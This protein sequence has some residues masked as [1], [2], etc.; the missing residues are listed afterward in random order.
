MPPDALLAA[1]LDVFRERGYTE[2]TLDLVA[3]RAQV[4]PDRV[5]ARFA[6][7]DQLLAALLKAYSPL[8]D[9]EVALDSVA[10]ESAEE[11]LRDALHRLVKVAQQHTAFF[12]LALMDAQVNKGAFLGNLNAQIF[13]KAMVLLEKIKATGQL[14]PASD[15]IL[16]RTLVSLLLGFVLSERA[17]PQIARVAMRLVPQHAWLDG[18]ID[19]LLYGVLEDEAR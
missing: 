18:M 16:G 3:Q 11:L 14:R 5:R 6:G 4:D 1:A 8:P 2:T 12:E 13:P 10:G 17:V 9:M 15:V 19:L 7:T